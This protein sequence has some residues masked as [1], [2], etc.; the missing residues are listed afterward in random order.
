MD[1]LQI[2]SIAT[3]D[4]LIR[5][6]YKGTYALDRVPK[7]IAKN[8][9]YIYNSDPENLSGRHWLLIDSLS[10][11][12]E[13]VFHY[14]S[15]GRKPTNP[16]IVSSLESLG[17]PVVYNDIQIQSVFSGVCAY[18]ALF[19]SFFLARDFEIEEIFERF[20][21]DN[22]LAN[23]SLVFNFISSVFHLNTPFPLDPSWEI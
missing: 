13:M 8:S 21:T 4:V 9:L 14:D 15:F 12:E 1:T 16:G 18:H 17:L 10:A 2:E 22:H 7:N 11:S 23:D 6:Y 3:K 19:L 5:R 20:Y